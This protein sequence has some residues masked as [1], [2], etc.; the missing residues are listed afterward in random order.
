MSRLDDAI[1]AGQALG[2]AALFFGCWD[3]PGHY[4]HDRRGH[5]LYRREIPVDFPAPWLRL[6]DSGLLKNGGNPDIPDGR[7]YW[8]CGGL[9]FW[10]AFVWWDRSGDRRGA[11]NSGFYVRGFG[12]PDASAAFDFARA[13]FPMIT[14]RQQHPLVLQE[15]A[16]PIRPAGSSS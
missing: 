9:T 3:R 10:Y 15:K 14:A 13:E 6:L 11:S 16:A 2:K 8:T 1:A 12:W 7:V 4:L 5:S